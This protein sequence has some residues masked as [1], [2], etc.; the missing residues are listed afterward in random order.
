MQVPVRDNKPFAADKARRHL[1]ML[2]YEGFAYL[3]GQQSMNPAE[4]L[5]RTLRADDVDARV[6]EAL[7]WLLLTYPRL[8]WEWM[9]RA[10]KQDD[11]QNR[12][13]FVVSLAR[14]VAESRGDAATAATLG[15]WER[16]LEPSRL[17]KTDAFCRTT[18]TTAETRWLRAHRS[19]EAA[20]WN[21]L[22]SLTADMVS[23]AG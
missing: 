9:V 10:A 6:V 13:G 16:T 15:T 21:V 20:Q 17:Q 5:L 18:L 22:S 7:P 3:G 1:G 23:R 19:P 14:G 8:D 11:L 2:G 12:L 4:V